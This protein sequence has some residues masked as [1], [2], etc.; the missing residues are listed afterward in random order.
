MG[1]PRSLCVLVPLVLSC[2]SLAISLS[3]CLSRRELVVLSRVGPAERQQLVYFRFC[4]L[5]VLFTRFQEVHEC[6]PISTCSCGSRDAVFGS[7]YSVGIIRPRSVSACVLSLTW[8]G[9]FLPMFLFSGLFLLMS[10]SFW[11]WMTDDVWSLGQATFF[12]GTGNQRS[13]PGQI[14][15]MTFDGSP[16]TCEDGLHGSWRFGVV[17]RV[18]LI[19]A[20]RDG[21]G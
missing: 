13:R 20:W 11:L 10:V 14:A 12:D 9:L 7:N 16:A 21:N 5:Q 8:F 2:H 4:N 6:R 3:L 15:S 1:F 17:S 19:F 18:Q